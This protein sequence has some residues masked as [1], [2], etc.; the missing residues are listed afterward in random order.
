MADSNK[1]DGKKSTPKGDKAVAS[2]IE[3]EIMHADDVAQAA[4]DE[5]RE[6]QVKRYS[7]KEEKDRVREFHQRA[8]EAAALAPPTVASAPADDNA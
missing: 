1:S 4:R 3:P 6:E 5:A 7:S 2:N 8:D